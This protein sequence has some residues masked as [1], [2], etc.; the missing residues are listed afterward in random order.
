VPGETARDKIDFAGAGAFWT[1][2]RVHLIRDANLENAMRD[3]MKI[4]PN[5][6]LITQ[7]H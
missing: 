4:R 1:G 3:A 5:D 2:I 6:P 7:G